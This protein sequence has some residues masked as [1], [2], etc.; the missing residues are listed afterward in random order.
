MITVS[1][2]AVV[3]A[4][5]RT[6]S[7]AVPIVAVVVIAVI[8]VAV[9]AMPVAIVASAVIA[10]I[11]RPSAYEHP[12]DEVARTIIAIGRAGIR[13]IA[14]VPVRTDRRGS[15]IIVAIIRVPVIVVAVVSVGVVIVVGIRVA[16]V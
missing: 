11:P 9:K 1:G 16:I 12:V 7:V 8:A 14:V 10:V 3:I 6:S 5:I 2:M 13:I 4:A 15:I